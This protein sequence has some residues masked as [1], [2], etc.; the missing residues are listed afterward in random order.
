L[1]KLDGL[2]LVE[3]WI[4]EDKEK[5]KS[6]IYGLNVPVGTWM[7]SVKVNNDEIWN[8]YVKTGQVKGFSIEGFFAEK[9]R[10]EEL[11]KE[12]EAGLKLLEIK[13]ALLDG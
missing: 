8:D 10:E 3:S 1:Y 12:I 9:E 5:D 13:K 11:K 4:V 2:T 6:A 7:G